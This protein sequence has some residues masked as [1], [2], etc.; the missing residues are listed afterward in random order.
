[1]MLVNTKK[2]LV[3]F[4]KKINLFKENCNTPTVC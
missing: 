2:V 4:Q 3:F 1:M